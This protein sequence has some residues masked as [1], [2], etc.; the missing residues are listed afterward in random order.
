MLSTDFTHHT[1]SLLTLT[2]PAHCR[3]SCLYRD[4]DYTT[5]F[6]RILA[7]CRVSD[8]ILAPTNVSRR[9]EWLRDVQSAS[10]DVARSRKYRRP[11][12]VAHTHSSQILWQH[13]VRCFC[14]I[15]PFIFFFYRQPNATSI[16]KSTHYLHLEHYTPKNRTHINFPRNDISVWQGA[17]AN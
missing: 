17:K 6:E 5:C 14:L 13:Y 11:G 1:A 12:G 9:Y 16:G 7:S 4:S 8:T 3:N 15:W 10:H 2:L